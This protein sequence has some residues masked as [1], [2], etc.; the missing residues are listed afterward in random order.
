MRNLLDRPVT[1]A[2]R[3]GKSAPSRFYLLRLMKTKSPGQKYRLR[4]EHLYS[5]GIFMLMTAA[6]ARR[7]HPS[8]V[9]Q[10]EN[11]TDQWRANR[12]G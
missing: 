5:Y 2:V 8:T 6:F 9:S 10:T 1:C 11:R 3:I 7:L 12:S 4:G